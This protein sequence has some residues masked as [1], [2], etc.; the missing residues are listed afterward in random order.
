MGIVVHTPVR[1][2]EICSSH[3]LGLMGIAI[4]AQGTPAI[5]P[6]LPPSEALPSSSPGPYVSK[7]ILPRWLCMNFLFF[8]CFLLLSVVLLLF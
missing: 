4:S 3:S 5:R 7:Y 6:R 2:N 1:A 8:F